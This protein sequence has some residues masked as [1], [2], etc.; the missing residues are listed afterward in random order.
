MQYFCAELT[1]LPMIFPKPTPSQLSFLLTVTSG[2]TCGNYYLIRVRGK[3]S[4]EHSAKITSFD[5]KEVTKRTRDIFPNVRFNLC[6]NVY[7]F[8][9]STGDGAYSSQYVKAIVDYEGTWCV[10]QASEVR[11]IHRV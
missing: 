1:S 3:D 5:F 8:S 6:Q 7:Y 10:L 2:D 9:I 11:E 4:K